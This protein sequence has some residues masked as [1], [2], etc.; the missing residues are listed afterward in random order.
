MA[1]E[2]IDGDFQ[3]EWRGIRMGGPGDA[4]GVTSMSGFG[5]LPG[6]NVADRD[7]LRAHGLTAGDDFL[8]GRTVTADLRLDSTTLE[9]VRLAT[10][11]LANSL[12]PGEGETP[13][14]VQ[15]PGVAG[16][17]KVRLL[18]R[19]RAKA[20]PVQLGYEIG[21]VTAAIMWEATDP[22][23]YDAEDTVQ[24]V[25]LPSG[26]GGLDVPVE[27]PASLTAQTES[28]SITVVNAGNFSSPWSARIDGPALNPVIRNVTT[29]LSIGFTI[30]LADGEWLD[31]DT[32][33][34][35]SV[36]LNG[37]SSRYYTITPGS[38]WWDMEPGQ[39]ELAFRASTTTTAALTV[40]S[41]SAWTS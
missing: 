1:G 10:E 12:T 3:I 4:I 29:G 41:R 13:L 17:R 6:V 9:E 40:T 14:V 36:L 21:D 15:I 8:G 38:T 11:R 32:A 20:L 33:G 27:V 34:A 35:R 28:G 26:G 7:R 23:L 2:L 30:D 5:D 24:S 37:T 22:R 25:G 18:A 31:V 39:T 16:G 19:A